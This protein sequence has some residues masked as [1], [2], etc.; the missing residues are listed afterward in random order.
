LQEFIFAFDTNSAPAVGQQ[1]TLHRRS[2]APV[3]ARIDLLL[4]RAAAGECDVVV[5]GNLAGEARG[6]LRLP[7][8]QFRSDRAAEP[9]LGKAALRRQSRVASQEL[10]FTCV[11][12]GS[13][14]RIG[15]DR[16]DDGALD[17]DEIDAGSDPADP[18]SLPE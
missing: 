15:V 9:P 7:S 1:V 6:W 16:D 17:R 11:P 2:D 10:T 8:G 4:A 5:K 12:V 13:G 18:A 14:E 3:D